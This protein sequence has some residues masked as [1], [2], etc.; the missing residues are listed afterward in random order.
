MSNLT[1]ESNIGYKVTFVLENKYEEK[2]PDLFDD[3]EN[4]ME[5]LDVISFRLRDTSLEEIFLR[6][7]SEEGELTPDPNILVEDFKLVLDDLANCVR[8]KGHNLVLRQFEALI[9][10]QWIGYKRR[11]PISIINWIAVLLAIGFAFGST[12][13][14]GKDFQL[15][16]LS[17]NLTQLPYIHT[18][19]ETLANTD[20]VNEMREF[21]TELIFWYDGHVNVLQNSDFSD[22]HLLKNKNFSRTVHYRYMFG[23][24]LGK[25]E[26]T[27]WFNTIPLHSLP[28]ALNLA[29][30]VIAR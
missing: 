7:G 24:S 16:P 21:F 30:N 28:F 10:L 18:F 27:V 15:I 13:I 6:F 11:L 17:F 25:E 3:L 22:F 1:V 26:I 20:D 23:A 5:R 14:Y 12:L 2:F 19:V 4:M 8:A 9:Y 29:H